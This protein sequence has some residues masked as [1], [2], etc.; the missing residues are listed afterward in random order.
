MTGER[1][2][3]ER[4]TNAAAAIERDPARAR[5]FG[6]F[7]DLV[8]LSSDRP[9]LVVHGNCQAESLRG[10]LQNADGAPCHSVRMPAVHELAAD[11]VPLLNRLLARARWVVTQPISDDYHDLPLGSAQVAAA[12]PQAQTVVVPVFRYA[13]LHP[14]QIV[15]NHRRLG[16]PPLVPYHDA[17]TVVEAAGLPSL[18]TTDDGI[19]AVSQWS[20]A[21]LE[22]REQA[23]GALPVSDLVL[24][25]GIAA[26]NTIN[27]PGNPV[28]IGLARRIEAAFGWPQEAVDP[29]RTLLSSV[30]APIDAQAVRALALD[31]DPVGPDWVVGGEPTPDAT[32]RSAHLAWYDEHPEVVDDLLRSAAHQLGLLG[33][34]GLP[35]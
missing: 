6:E 11:E 3:G 23:A 26:A 28:L 31:A 18:E 33:A 34:R 16:D 22:R 27:H 17:R 21:E 32:V 8:P 1:M 30:I 24:P 14:W 5:H 9:L 35:G 25:A 10:L 4:I 29:G 13:G 2:T 15:R 12:A 20:L 7:Y 19:R